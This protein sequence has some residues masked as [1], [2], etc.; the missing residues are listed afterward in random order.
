VLKILLFDIDGTLVLTGG[1]G[2]RAMAYAFAEVFG[3]TDGFERVPMNGR[4]DSWIVGQVMAVHGIEYT[5]ARMRQFRDLYVHR[6]TDEIHSPGPRKGVMPGVR[7]LLDRLAS[8]GDAC[9]ALLT[10]NFEA[11]ARIKLEYFDLWRYFRCGAFGDHAFERNGL[12][13]T[14]LDRLEACGV[15][16]VPRS[17]VL[18]V[19]DTPLDVA[20]ARAGG[21]RSIA[22]ATGS[23]TVKDLQESGAD[24][25][26]SDLRDLRAVLDAC[27]FAQ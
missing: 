2:A 21:A 22:V 26:F 20:V 18:I 7:P 11:G 15:P 4:T 19:G 3:V 17:D 13:A 1:A 8:R 25:V 5:D 23:H 14:A 6:L 16:P 9:L 24:V 12:L 10:G 27:G